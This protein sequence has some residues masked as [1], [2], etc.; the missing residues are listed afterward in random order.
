LLCACASGLEL[1]AAA[2]WFAPS[3]AAGG[4]VVVGVVPPVDG[5]PP[6]LGVGVVGTGFDGFVGFG[7]RLATTG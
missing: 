7:G 2:G 4:W 5:V 3:L 6:W 1:A